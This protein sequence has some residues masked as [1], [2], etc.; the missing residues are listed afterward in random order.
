VPVAGAQHTSAYV[1]QHTSVS[2][3]E[4]TSVTLVVR[5]CGLP[6]AAAQCSA[7]TPVFHVNIYIYSW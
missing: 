3:R 6:V 2:I 1:S 7:E 4:H 5:T